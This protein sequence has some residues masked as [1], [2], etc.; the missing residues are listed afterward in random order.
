[1]IF[2]NLYLP[3]LDFSGDNKKYIFPQI[4]PHFISAYGR[5]CSSGNEVVRVVISHDWVILFG[6]DRKEQVFFVVQRI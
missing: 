5:I 6:N 2:P 1:M 4:I 3:S